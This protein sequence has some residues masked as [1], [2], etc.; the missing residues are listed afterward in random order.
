[1]AYV[2]WQM[3]GLE[4]V[5][6]SC[7]WGCPCQFNALPSHG[8][9]RALTFVQ[10]E[11]GR[12]GD[13]PLDGLRWGI[14]AAWPGPDSFRERNLSGRSW[15]SAPTPSNA[16]RSKRL[17]T[18][19]TP[20]RGRSSGR[21]S[22]PPFRPCFRPSRGR[23]SSR[24]TSTTRTA[25]LFV[26]GVVEGSVAADQEPEDRRAA[27][28]PRHAAERLRVHRSRVRQ[29]ARHRR[30]RHPARVQRHARPP[31]PHPLDHAR[32]GPVGRRGVQP[33]ECRS[34]SL[35]TA[36]CECANTR[37]RKRSRIRG[38]RKRSSSSTGSIGNARLRA[39]AKSPR[40]V[41]LDRPSRT[42]NLDAQRGRT[43]A[44]PSSGCSRPGRASPAASHDGRQR[45]RAGRSRRA[46]SGR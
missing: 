25:S 19:A 42:E 10:V 12:Y 35:G 11:R 13:V 18:A 22:R 38:S 28:R 27:S 37:T 36:R 40:P 5:N 39:A 23:S 6:C 3:Q 46:A 16:R 29:R 14:L 44:S 31:G 26:P 9:C 43:T 8:H 41:R 34:S 15:M 30:R 32:R 45:L 2:D 1:M 33:P 4:V 17:P 20:S 24:S 7:E 21:S